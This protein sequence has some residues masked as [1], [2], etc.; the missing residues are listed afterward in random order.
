MTVVVVM[1]AVIAV[2]APSGYSGSGDRRAMLAGLDSETEMR[3]LSNGE[4]GS[5]RFELEVRYAFGYT[6]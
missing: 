4:V 3:W 6:S 2:H 1:E 5:R